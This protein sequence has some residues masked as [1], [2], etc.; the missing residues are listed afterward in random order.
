M[1]HFLTAILLGIIEGLTEFIPVSSTGHLILAGKLLGFEGP[2]GKLFEVFIQFGAV[3]AVIWC[4]REKCY[5]VVT[6]LGSD[7]GAQRFARNICLA[8][9]PAMLLGGL[10]FDF[11]K[12]TLFDPMIVAVALII[13]GVLILLIEKF[14]PAPT[15]ASTEAMSRRTALLIGCIQCLAMIPG[16]SRSGATIMGAL[17]CRV[18]RKAAAEFSFFLA[19]PT[20]LAASSY[21]LYRNF[22]LLDDH[23]ITVLALGFG[24]AFITAMLVVRA[25]VG[26]VGR[27]GF[28]PFAIYRILLGGVMLLFVL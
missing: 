3:M 10:L 26:F 13:G 1:E 15:I 5:Q 25:V 28:V 16:V 23:S 14:K 7:V 21:D 22:H 20:M 19:I 27:Y 6:G 17:L 9:L 11:I 2:P 12:T 18:E 8:V 24:A 4:Y